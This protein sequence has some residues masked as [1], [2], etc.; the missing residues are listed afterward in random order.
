MERLHRWRI[1]YQKKAVG[2]RAVDS[3]PKLANF[4][5]AFADNLVKLF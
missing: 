3:A 2:S 1:Y 4:I 5:D